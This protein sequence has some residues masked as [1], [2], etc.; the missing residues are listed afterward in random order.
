MERVTYE[1]LAQF[2][3]SATDEVSA[4]MRTLHK[5]VYSNTLHEPL[6][7]KN[8]RLINGDVGDAITA[9]KQQEGDPFDPLAAYVWSRVWQNWDSLTDS[10]SWSF[11]GYYEGP[12][13]NRSMPIIH[14]CRSNWSV[15]KCS[16]R[17]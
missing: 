13:R 9:L 7:W 14:G 6:G 8:T 15:R 4:L 16:T 12:G 3:A 5:L 10:A 1:A 11:H 17:D 2:V